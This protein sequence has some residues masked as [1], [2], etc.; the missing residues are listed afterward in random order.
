[1]Q[2]ALHDRCLLKAMTDTCRPERRFTS[3]ID[4]VRKESDTWNRWA[5][6]TTSTTLPGHK[7]RAEA[8]RSGR[9]L[10]V[11]CKDLLFPPAAAQSIKGHLHK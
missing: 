5:L 9:W 2:K 7:M 8:S 6:R 1:M 4:A 10:D 11:A 3:T